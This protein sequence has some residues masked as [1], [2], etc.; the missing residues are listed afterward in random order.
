MFPVTISG[1]FTPPV[2]ITG[3][4][5]VVRLDQPEQPGAGRS[6]TAAII[7]THPQAAEVIAV[8]KAI[9]DSQKEQ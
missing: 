9:I 2:T 8:I 7:L 3:D 4:D 5:D 6:V 1:E